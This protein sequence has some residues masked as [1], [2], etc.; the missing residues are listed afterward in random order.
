MKEQF[1]SESIEPVAATFDAARMAMGEPGLPREFIWRGRHIIIVNVRLSWKETGLCRHGSGERYVRKHWY[2]VETASD[3]IMKLYFE[4]Q[5]R[6][7]QKFAR[8][9][10]FSVSHEEPK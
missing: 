3:G 4:R 1:V 10:L 6:G 5:P 8:W 9:W 7:K 2:E